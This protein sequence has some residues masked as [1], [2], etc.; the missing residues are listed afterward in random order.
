[1]RYLRHQTTG[2]NPKDAVFG[3]TI[4][5]SD[6]TSTTHGKGIGNGSYKAAKSIIS[7]EKYKEH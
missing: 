3:M 2:A 5:I 1:M 6:A 4:L 7:A